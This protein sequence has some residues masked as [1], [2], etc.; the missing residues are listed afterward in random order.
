[1]ATLIAAKVVDDALPR[2][3]SIHSSQYTRYRGKNIEPDKKKEKSS[4]GS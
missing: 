2:V 1:M 3:N 4:I